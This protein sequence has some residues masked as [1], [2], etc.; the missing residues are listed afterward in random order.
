MRATGGQ[1]AMKTGAEGVFVAIIPGRRLDVALKIT[2][3]AGRASEVAIAALLMHL[4]VLDRDHPATR[5]RLD[6]TQ[7]NWRGLVTGRP[8]PAPGFPA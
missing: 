2:D 6:S 7:R 8:C 5:A 3:G 4:G 1:V